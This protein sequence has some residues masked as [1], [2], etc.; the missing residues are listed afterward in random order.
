MSGPGKGDGGL[1]N[2]KRAVNGSGFTAKNVDKSNANP[3]I[4]HMGDTGSYGYR[5]SLQG[6]GS[7]HLDLMSRFEL[8]RPSSLY[9]NAARAEVDDLAGIT[10]PLDQHIMVKLDPRRD[11]SFL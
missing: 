8:Q 2:F 7:H 4:F 10:G 11:S 1:E 6:Q 5:S 9:E 3:V